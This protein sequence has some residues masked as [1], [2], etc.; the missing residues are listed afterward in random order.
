V[1]AARLRGAV[2]AGLA[3]L[4]LT[5]S[6]VALAEPLQVTV[7]SASAGTD[8]R[9]G[10]PVLNIRLANESRKAFAT[11]SETHVGHP[12][13]MRIDGKSV[14]KPVMREPITGGVLQI[15]MDSM[16]RARELADRL[17]QGPT[18]VEVEAASN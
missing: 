16:E 7:I 6:N 11:L 1:S 12:V 17:S 15:T 3:A 18:V 8:A 2:F 13:E 9:S 14:A 10:R 5:S 4:A